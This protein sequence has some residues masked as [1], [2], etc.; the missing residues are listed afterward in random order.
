MVEV[1]SAK[2]RTAI[3]LA[4]AIWTSWKD[5]ALA[6]VF[7]SQKFSVVPLILSE[8][9]FATLLAITLSSS[10][11]VAIVALHLVHLHRQLIGISL[12]VTPQTLCAT[13][14]TTPISTFS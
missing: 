9:E 4:V 2:M 7:V 10:G 6:P 3:L 11:M 13:G 12:A 14:T 1:L 8:M 5:L